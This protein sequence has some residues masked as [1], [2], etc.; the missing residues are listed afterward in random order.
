MT[1]KHTTQ[2]QSAPPT[3]NMRSRI[4]LVGL[5]LMVAA[6]LGACGSD[7]DAAAPLATAED[8]AVTDTNEASN[9]DD[10]DTAGDTDTNADADTLVDEDLAHELFLDCLER[11]GLASGPDGPAPADGEP[12]DP[13]AVIDKCSAEVPASDFDSD[14]EAEAAFAD[15]VLAVETCLADAGISAT[16][17]GANG[18]ISMMPDPGSDMAAFDAV[19]EGCFE[20]SDTDGGQS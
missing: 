17:S 13:V 8:A 12:V 2:V 19:A 5:V 14:P 16:V 20:A 11:N 1:R 15:R 4:W 6:A 18:R 7:D 9:V 3:K 10:S